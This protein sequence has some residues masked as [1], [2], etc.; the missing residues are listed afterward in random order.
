MCPSVPNLFAVEQDIIRGGQPNSEGCIYLKSQGITDII[1]L[2]TEEE[3]SD[4]PAEALGMIVHRFPIPWWRQ[5]VLRPKQ[6]DLQAIVALIKPHTFI[7]CLRG[8]DRTGLAVACFRLSQG[9][10]KED[11][12]MEMAAHG[13]HS[14]LQGLQGR[15]NSENPADWIHA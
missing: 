4:A 9:W 15:W 2:S 1:K 5:L 11:A 6:S 8:E 14:S 10:T 13:F 3:G 12:Y 7:H